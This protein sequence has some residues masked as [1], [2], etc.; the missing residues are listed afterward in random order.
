MALDLMPFYSTEF[1]HITKQHQ[2]FVLQDLK[3]L[4]AIH[5]ILVDITNAGAPM[6]MTS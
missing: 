5:L 4:G 6:F 2:H 3:E 1:W